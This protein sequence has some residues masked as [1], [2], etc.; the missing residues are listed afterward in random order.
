MSEIPYPVHY[1]SVD[2]VFVDI[3][4]L[5]QKRKEKIERN[6]SL[7]AFGW[8]VLHFKFYHLCHCSSVS[9]PLF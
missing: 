1:R 4:A 7:F 6:N 9:R 5:L 3:R 2:F 8:P